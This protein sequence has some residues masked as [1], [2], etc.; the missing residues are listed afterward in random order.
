M[1]LIVLLSWRVLF[2]AHFLFFMVVPGP[3][4]VTIQNCDTVSVEGL[5]FSWLLSMDVAN[6]RELSLGGG[7]FSLEPTA[8]NVGEHGPG[9]SVGS[10]NNCI[11]VYIIFSC[12][13]IV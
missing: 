11:L 4:S 1:C 5:A 2:S 9:M 6:V 3:L 12:D 13:N 8:A 10:H 7:S